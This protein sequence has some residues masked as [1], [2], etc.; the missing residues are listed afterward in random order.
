VQCPNCG[1]ESQVSETRKAGKHTVRRRRVCLTCNQRFTTH[2]QIA[3]PQLKVEKR[4]GGTEP[5][6]RAKLRRCV[7]RVARHR[8]LDDEVLEDVVEHV[9]AKLMNAR[10][11]RWWR[12]AELVLDT[13]RGVDGVAAQRLAAN[14][15]DEG[16]VLRLEDA[17]G[18][19]QEPPQLGL[20]E[21]DE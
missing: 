11:V 13:L 16:G 18:P 1:G 21:P 14:Y 6:Q 9:E 19:A 20:F 4:R 12:I 15:L 17:A 5:Y 7:E 8:A 2:E 3:P 10:T